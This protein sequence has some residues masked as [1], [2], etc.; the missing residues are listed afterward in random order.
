MKYAINK[1]ILLKKIL[2]LDAIAGGSTAIICL[3]FAAKLM[4]LL[5]LEMN[6]IKMIASITLL[7]ALVAL[8][9]A[10]QKIVPITLLRVL[11]YANWVWVIISIF[12]LYFHFSIAT[13][14]GLLFLTLQIIVVGGLAYFEGRQIVKH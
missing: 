8:Y 6:T 1:P 9:L 13:M 10:N 11:V 12:L 4:Q 14:L 2:W 3:L 7:Y 5:G